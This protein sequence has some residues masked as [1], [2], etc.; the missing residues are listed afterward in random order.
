MCSAQILPFSQTHQGETGFSRY[1]LTK[2]KYRY[3][4]DIATDMRIKLPTIPP[5]LQDLLRRMSYNIVHTSSL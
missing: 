3:L 1:A 5:I 4:L 2:S